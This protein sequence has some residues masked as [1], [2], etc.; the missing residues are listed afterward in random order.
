MI[1]LQTY[2]QPVK[3]I[4]TDIQ[5][6]IFFITNIS[7]MFSFSLV[8]NFI[9]NPGKRVPSFLPLPNGQG[10][11]T[12]CELLRYVTVMQLSSWKYTVKNNLTFRPSTFWKKLRY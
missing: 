7:R 11:N 12:N 2:I 3:N 8:P 1:R 4:H 6:C 10:K 5:I 9:F